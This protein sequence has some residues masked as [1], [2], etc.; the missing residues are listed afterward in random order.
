M[1]RSLLTLAI[2]AIAACPG[3]G[4]ST[5]L[6]APDGSKV[7]VNR[8]GE[9]TIISMKDKTGQSASMGLGKEVPLPDGFPTALVYPGARRAWAIKDKVLITVHFLTPDLPQKAAEFYQ[10]KLKAE[11]FAFHDFSVLMQADGGVLQANKEAENRT[12]RIVIGRVKNS[13]TGVSE[14]NVNVTH[15]LMRLPR[16]P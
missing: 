11:G 7:T 16:T 4:R 6:T 3:C 2:T 15:G 1:N 5:S 10:A 14:T 13:D 9:G 8:E 12:C